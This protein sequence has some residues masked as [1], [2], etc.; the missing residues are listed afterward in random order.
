[1]QE[2]GSPLTVPPA[3]LDALYRIS[4]MDAKRNKWSLSGID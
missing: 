4:T 1:M 2:E 3:R